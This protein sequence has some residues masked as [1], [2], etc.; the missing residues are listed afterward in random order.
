LLLQLSEQNTLVLTVDNVVCCAKSLIPISCNSLLHHDAKSTEQLYANTLLCS[1]FE[2]IFSTISILIECSRGAVMQV[3]VS[4]NVICV[5]THLLIAQHATYLCIITFAET[6]SDC[7]V[8]N[9]LWQ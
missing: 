7:D 2:S 6:K 1:Y 5:Y 8:I 9:A 4:I 3:I